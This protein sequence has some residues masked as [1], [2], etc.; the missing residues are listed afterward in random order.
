MTDPVPGLTIE[1]QP[2]PVVIRMLGYGEARGEGPVG[3][4]AVLW[5]L[6][7]RALKRDTSLKHEALRRLQFSCFNDDDPNRA[8]LLTAY[9]TDPAAWASV[10][11]VATM[12]E[13]GHTA[14]PTLGSTHY[15]VASMP[16]PPAWASAEN[17]WQHR[18]RIKSHEFGVAA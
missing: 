11:A 9:K 13:H 7:N 3:I 4:A 16:N 10:D 1:Q 18:A 12:F 6:R 8:K 2:E 17:G 15:F 14:D 5:V